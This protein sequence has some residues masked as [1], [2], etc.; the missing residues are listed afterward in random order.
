MKNPDDKK[1]IALFD[2]DGTITS[3]DS[4]GAFVVYNFG[5][6]K[7]A[8]VA[9]LYAPVHLL[10]R[11]NVI[12]STS[13]KNFLFPFFLKNITVANFEK[14]CADFCKIK[15]PGM[16]YQKAVEEIKWHLQQN[17]EVIIISASP[18]DWIKPWAETIGV[19]HYISSQLEVANNKL[20]G[21]LDGENCN[22]EQ[23][24]VRIKKEIPNINEYEIYAYGN[25]KGD[26]FMLDLADHSFY[27]KFQS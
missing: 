9:V 11:L 17:H 12:S 16:I 18:A 2:F 3:K 6:V 5:A 4:L 7:C 20:T 27:K 15:L 13:A 21:K 1:V 14:M 26:R 10:Y 23:K 24:V 8:L 19:K 22:H 25:S